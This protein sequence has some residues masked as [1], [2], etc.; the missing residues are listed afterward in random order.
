MSDNLIKE[1]I[2][3]SLSIGEQSDTLNQEIHYKTN[4]VLNTPELSKEEIERKRK[5]N[6]V[7]L[8][9]KNIDLINFVGSNLS[10]L[11]IM[12]SLDTTKTI[13]LL[14]ILNNVFKE[15]QNII[16]PENSKKFDF[17]EDF[18][19]EN[20][21]N[22]KLNEIIN[23]IKNLKKRLD[24]LSKSK[25]KKDFGINTDINIMS[26][27]IEEELK[28]LKEEQ[29]KNLDI[30]IKENSELKKQIKKLKK[31]LVNLIKKDLSKNN[32][33]YQS[34]LK[35][36][37]ISNNGGFFTTL[38]IDNPNNIDTKNYRKNTKENKGN[39]V[40]PIINNNNTGNNNFI[41]KNSPKFYSLKKEKTKQFIFQS[42]NHSF[43]RN[44]SNIPHIIRLNFNKKI[45]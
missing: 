3:S 36:N 8:H 42:N 21:R 34:P 27:G 22:N 37:T 32:N 43:Q 33:N 26:K 1:S 35:G 6:P 24:E 14:S 2:F 17:V 29:K 4:I 39:N 41:K 44:K 9:A 28:E 40:M 15:I 23:S 25:I 10:K 18:I 16:L 19:E 38:Y 5:S 7:V 20:E 31:D 45:K 13:D 11:K 12:N 30:L